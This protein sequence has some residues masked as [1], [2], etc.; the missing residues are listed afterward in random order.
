MTAL[1]ISISSNSSDES[2]GSFIPRVILFGS[3]PIEAPVVPADLSAAPGHVSSAPY[4][5]MVAR[6][7]SR[8]ASPSGSSSP[9]TFTS[10]IPTALILPAPPTIVAPPG[11]FDRKEDGWTLPSHYLALRHSTSDQTL[12]GHTSPVTTIADSSTPSI[13]IF[14][15]P[16][17]TSWGSE[18][19]RH[20]RSAPLSTMHPSMMSESSVGDSSSESS[21]EPSRKRCRSHAA[22]TPLPIP[23]P[24]A[25][26][27]THVDLLPPRKRFRYSYSSED[28]IEEDIDA[29][30]LADMEVD[31]G[32][33]A[34]IGIEVSVEVVSEDGKEYEAESSVRGTRQLETGSLIASEERAG[35]IDRVATLER[36]NTRL[37]DTLRMKSVR[38]DRLRFRRLETFAAR[39]LE[40]LAA[41]EANRAAE[42]VV[43]SQSH[44]RD[45]GDNINGEGNGDGNGGVNGDGNGE[46]NGNKNER[47]NRN[48]NSNGNDR[49]VMLVAREC[50]YHDF[51]KCQ[52]LNFKGTKGVVRLK[53]WFEKMETIFH[54]NNCPEKYKLKLTMLCTKMVPEE[55]D[56]VKK[57]I[58]G[59]PDNIQGNGYAA[60]GVE[61]KRRLGINQNDNRVQQPLCKRQ[62]VDGQNVARAY[63]AS[64]N[65]K[66][67]YAWPWP[68]CNNCKLHHEGTYTMKYRNCNKAEHMT[69]DYKKAVAA[70]TTQRA[71]IVNQR[72]GTSFVSTTFSAL[73]DVISSIID[74]SYAVELL[75][76]RVSKTNTVLRGYT[77]GLLCHQFNIDLMPIE[78]GSFNVIIGMDWLANHHAVIVCD[79]KILRIPYGYE[80]L[81]VQGDRSGEGKKSKLSIIS[82]TKT[83]KY[84][85]KGCLIFLAQVTKKENKDKSKEKRLEDVPTVRDFLEDFLGLSP[86]RQVEFQI[87]LVPGAAPIAR[88]PYT[89][90]PSELQDLS[91]QLQELSDKGFI[92]PSSS[93]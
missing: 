11:G 53:K 75:N 12:Y 57:F 44:N 77:L 92:R 76:R 40:A 93:P 25:L 90:T 78:L 88:A 66:R 15:P 14:P 20:Y 56:R 28:S 89:L 49:G 24:G 23:A 18:A 47:G 62:D 64:N 31:A 58:G 55:E 67:G 48:G 70:T 50:T 13:F 34:G 41:Y 73:L 80:V 8:V 4:D 1:V 9:T 52:P 42:L 65:E 63:T 68:Y 54:I 69:R 33:D 36:S 86:M 72:V 71:P 43:E 21:V 26:V 74:I 85:K 27:P 59:L 7:R 30:V 3:I 46:G 82:C 6:W 83:Q 51:V 91:T 60:K 17:R 39:R 29:D 87:D 37:R 61:N 81:I 16:T 38:V 45:D 5:A 35:L 19:F 22:T 84:I 2:V 10:E 32:V 79:E